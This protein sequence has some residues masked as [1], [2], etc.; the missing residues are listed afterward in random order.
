MRVEIIFSSLVEDHLL[1]NQCIH[2]S[3]NIMYTVT[4][5]SLAINTIM[6]VYSK[7]PSAAKLS[8]YCYHEAKYNKL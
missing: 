3:L 1:L 2:K 8:Y 7:K 5:L 4:G 6:Y